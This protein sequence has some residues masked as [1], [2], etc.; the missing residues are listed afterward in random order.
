MGYSYYPLPDE[1]GAR[2]I[3]LVSLLP[4]SGDLR[5]QFPAKATRLDLDA[6]EPFE[7]L[8]YVWGSKDNPVEVEVVRNSGTRKSDDES[9]CQ[10]MSI[11]QNLATALRHLRHQDEARILWID[12]ICID[13]SNLE[14]KSSQVAI[15]GEVYKHA[16]QVIVWL[17]SATDNS[18]RALRVLGEI[19]SQVTVD[20]NDFFMSPSPDARDATL[21]LQHVPF[22]SY[23]TVDDAI[24]V[25]ALW[26]RAWFERVWVRQEVALARSA[27]FQAGHS[28]L[29]RDLMQNAAYC[30]YHKS[31][32]APIFTGKNDGKTI[33]EGISSSCSAREFSPLSRI[34]GGA[35]VYLVKAMCQPPIRFFPSRLYYYLEGMHCG[36]SRDRVYSMLSLLRGLDNETLDFV[37]NYRASVA[38]C[39]RDLAL[40]HI[41]A[42]RS[43]NFLASCSL[44]YKTV[45]TAQDLP[46]L[47][48]RLPGLPSWVPDWSVDS[49]R[50]RSS[51]P[52]TGGQPFLAFTEYLG[53][54]VLR[55]SG[56]YCGTVSATSVIDVH[57]SSLALFHSL[58]TACQELDIPFI[59]EIDEKTTYPFTGESWATTLSRVLVM[60][61]LYENFEPRDPGIISTQTM[62]RTITRILGLD[63]NLS[64]ADNWPGGSDDPD[65]DLIL[66]ARSIRG[67]VAGRKLFKTSDGYI[68]LGPAYM[69]PGDKICLLLGSDFLVALRSQHSGTP[70][71][72][73]IH[74]QSAG[75]N[76]IDISSTLETGEQFLVVG[77]CFVPGLM[78]GEPLLGSLPPQKHLIMRSV[79]GGDYQICVHDAQTGK[80]TL[81]DP[82]IQTLESR[83]SNALQEK[84]IEEAV[85]IEPCD[86]FYGEDGEPRYE[87]KPE[88]F[89]ILGIN[90]RYFD[91]V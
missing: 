84:G 15:M 77:E 21:G 45:A 19:G 56:V 41:A 83:L 7:A 53:S 10:T 58:R 43:L 76:N 82:R 90:M 50:H 1:T 17:G 60:D 6:I 68:G 88:Y 51:P 18:D 49:D 8:S 48:Y 69:R 73:A 36:D 37:P 63:A 23:F 34:S 81:R 61:R 86:K 39:Y 27:I 89:S 38:D 2:H 87:V 91:L 32:D 11:T 44:S 85:V 9:H 33:L 28:T 78:A 31:I 25:E 42:E 40:R 72:G 59:H 57:S 24:A 80:A 74:N 47:A 54:G 30:F 64:P 29:S 71:S 13:Q 52:I 26:A 20:W 46:K 62:V 5:L 3:R 55:V 16:R 66:A 22:P 70:A 4:G 79:D 14:E 65:S 12:A 75:I 35:R 67:K